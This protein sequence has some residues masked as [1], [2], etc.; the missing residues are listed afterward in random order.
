[1]VHAKSNLLLS[2]EF[3]GIP[4][5]ISPNC[6]TASRRML[7]LCLRNI[8]AL[9]AECPCPVRRTSVPCPR[10]ISALPAEFCALFTDHPCS[11]HRTLCS[12]RDVL[13]SVYYV[14][15]YPQSD[16]LAKL[17]NVVARMPSFR[18]SLIVVTE[19]KSPNDLQ[20]AAS[21]LISHWSYL[22]ISKSI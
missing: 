22:D 21:G 9:S 18:K 17:P 12:V 2:D 16:W 20:D 11:V 19:R 15:V 10:N 3:W 13:A 7:V 5:W 8:C 4:S 14:S 6:H 1:M